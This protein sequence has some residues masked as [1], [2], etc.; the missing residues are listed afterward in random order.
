MHTPK[1]SIITVNLNNAEGLRK[2]IESVVN[3]TFTDY[4]YII[5]DGGSTDGSVDIIKQY[6]EK[7]TNWVSEPDKGIYN[8]MNKGILKA[9]GE[10]CQFL[11]SGDWLINQNVLKNVFAVNNNEDII[12][13]NVQTDKGTIE[14]PEK[15]TLKFFF[16][17]T[18][19]HQSVFHKTDLFGKYGLYKEELF[20][21]ADWQF[22]VNALITN[23]STYKFVNKIICFYDYNGISSNPKLFKILV[24]Q[25]EEVLKK[26]FPMFYDDYIEFQKQNNELYYYKSSKIV[27]LVRRIQKSNLYHKIRT[28]KLWR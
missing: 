19:C 17:S 20:I 3:Q 15:L 27:Q 12:Y 22:L 6:E 16:Q 4:E 8:A 24:S 1:L 14:N 18:I 21:I 23:N 7:I 28:L 10:Y 26:D 5:I 2:T 13:G 11:N 25:R 9:K